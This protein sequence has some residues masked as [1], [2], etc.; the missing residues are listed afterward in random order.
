[1]R[2]TVALAPIFLA[3]MAASVRPAHADFNSAVAAYAQGNFRSAFQDFLELAKQRDIMAQDIV[4]IMYHRGNGVPKDDVQAYM[5]LDLAAHAGDPDAAK[6]RDEMI[7]PDMT[8]S[9]I[10]KARELSKSSPLYQEDAPGPLVE[11]PHRDAESPAEPAPPRTEQLALA[12]VDETP[13]SELQQSSPPN[14][15][16]SADPL[17]TRAL[18]SHAAAQRSARHHWTIQVVAVQGKPEAEREWQRLRNR[19]PDLLRGL[20]PT[21]ERAEAD[22]MHRSYYRVRIGAWKDK[23][24]PDAIC[25]KL[26]QRGE[27][28]LVLQRLS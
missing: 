9:D 10:A 6:F 23:Q 26:K 12:Q 20:T 19:Y 28:C 2:L 16:A 22:A 11:S 8:P 3:A 25:S 14:P 18:P 24:A 15:A 1:M 21:V 17:A 5:W 7:A 27:R 13:S 4:A